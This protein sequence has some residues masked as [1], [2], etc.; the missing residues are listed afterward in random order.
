M[1]LSER[2]KPCT[3]LI[4]VSYKEKNDEFETDA[5]GFALKVDK[6]TLLDPI[7][8]NDLVLMTCAH[9]ILKSGQL[10]NSSITIPT[11]SF[12]NVSV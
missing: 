10:S 3:W 8:E 11:T 5:T 2:L 7:E 1:K 9:Y 12:S 4:K 6:K